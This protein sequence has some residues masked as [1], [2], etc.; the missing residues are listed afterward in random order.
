MSKSAMTPSFIGRMAVMVPGVLPSISLATR[1]TALPFLSTRLV[2][3]LTATTDG[4]FRTMPW[5]R[6]QTRV[7]QVPRSMPMSILN[8]PRREFSTPSHP[9]SLGLLVRDSKG[10]EVPLAPLHS[11]AS[12]PEATSVWQVL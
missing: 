7:L 1:P 8:R 10:A 9:S 12:V 3:F 6:T 4:S 5:P 11:P 2:P